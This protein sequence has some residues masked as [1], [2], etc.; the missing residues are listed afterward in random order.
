MDYALIVDDDNDMA[1]AIKL[2]LML[3][4]LEAQVFN[5]ARDAAN[6]LLNAKELPAVAI[7]DLNM[8]EVSGWDMLE[9]VRRHPRLKTL[10]FIILT[11]ETYPRFRE[12][13]RA[14]GADGYLT[15]PVTVDELEIAINRARSAHG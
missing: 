11:S 3:L 8:P 13:A 14:A 10:P 6:F 12:Q 15:K 7:V 9:F 1:N 2:M 4:D 5:N